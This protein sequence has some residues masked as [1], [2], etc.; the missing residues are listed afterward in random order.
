MQ[1]DAIK[2]DTGVTCTRACRDQF[3]ASAINV[4]HWKPA[5]IIATPYL[6]LS[7]VPSYQSADALLC[8]QNTLFVFKTWSVVTQVE[9]NMSQSEKI[10]RCI[11]VRSF[12]IPGRST[13]TVY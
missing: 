9:K 1:K 11:D 13:F 3:A 7:Y 10:Y 12:V 6:L 8:L 2:Y 5:I 4:H